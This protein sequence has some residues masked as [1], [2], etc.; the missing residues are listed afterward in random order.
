MHHNVS[1]HL[2]P[3]TLNRRFALCLRILIPHIFIVCAGG[4]SLL[5]F[6]T[7]AVV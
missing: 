4:A 5:A 2:Y 1:D 6:L 7:S 3:E